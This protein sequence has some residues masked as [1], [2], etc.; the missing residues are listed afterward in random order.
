VALPYDGC[1][2]I[3]RNSFGCSGLE[4]WWNLINSDAAK[5]PTIIRNKESIIKRNVVEH[6]ISSEI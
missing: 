2:A 1:L 4:Y 3:S 5:H 6:V